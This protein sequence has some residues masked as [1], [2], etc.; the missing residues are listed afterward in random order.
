MRRRLIEKKKRHS[1]CS[2]VFH[3]RTISKMMS[4][5]N[6]LGGTFIPHIKKV[7][8]SFIFQRQTYDKLFQ[9]DHFSG[10][11][12]RL[13]QNSKFCAKNMRHWHLPFI[14]QNTQRPL[15]I[16][17]KHR[18]VSLQNTFDESLFIHASHYVG[19]ECI[20]NHKTE[21]CYFYGLREEQATQLLTSFEAIQSISVEVRGEL[22]HLLHK[23]K[24]FGNQI[25]KKNT[26][27][28][29]SLKLG[30]TADISDVEGSK[31]K[32]KVKRKRKKE[33]SQSSST[34]KKR[35]KKKSKEKKKK[36]FNRKRKGAIELVREKVKVIKVPS[37]HVGSTPVII[38][39]EK[40]K[41][42][43]IQQNLNRSICHQQ[44]YER[45]ITMKNVTKH[46]EQV[47]QIDF[48]SFPLGVTPVSVFSKSRALVQIDHQKKLDEGVGKKLSSQTTP[49]SAIKA[50]DSS[51]NNK[52]QSKGQDVQLPIEDITGFENRFEKKIET[53][54]FEI[55]SDNQ[56]MPFGHSVVG[57][58]HIDHN[59]HDNIITEMVEPSPVTMLPASQLVSAKKTMKTD[60]EILS[61]LCSENFLETWSQ[62]ASEL[63]S[64]KWV[65]YA[66]M[67]NLTE[68]NYRTLMNKKICLH[69]CILVDECWVDVELPNYSSIKIIS[70]ASWSNQSKTTNPKGFIK[71]FVQ[72]VASDR[73]KRIHLIFVIDSAK[74]NEHVIE[75]VNLQNAIVKQQGCPCDCLC[76]QYIQASLLSTTIAM[77]ASKNL[78]NQSLNGSLF[79]GNILEQ[80]RFLLSVVPTL[81]VFDCLRFFCHNTKVV[82]KDE[83]VNI[84]KSNYGTNT[85]TRSV[86]QLNIALDTI[87]Q[88]YPLN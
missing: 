11:V 54:E 24:E 2:D 5:Y 71:K 15:L 10:E 56:G 63:S 62:A 55:M 72:L 66:H 78:I 77:I 57:Y 34:D 33:L 50:G 30:I 69:D 4:P 18:G 7:K 59:Q 80:A 64:G 43:S 65:N 51:K 36:H 49:Q 85:R 13:F 86:Q 8:P 70:L 74:L 20:S 39:H 40:Y 27:Q 87:L 1:S 9:V 26:Q 67:E 14:R 42:T 68:V 6:L 17:I 38:T 79:E 25:I 58:K 48:P 31:A 3:Y 52:N 61:L 73:Y 21:I 47:P 19:K 83:M 23:I 84:S 60:E 53:E 29:E 45:D 81:T 82:L 44:M 32:Q 41:V 75:I 16:P 46:I 37:L 88:N 22:I 12:T 35:R 28:E 76:I